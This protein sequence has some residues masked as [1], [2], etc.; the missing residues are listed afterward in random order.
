MRQYKVTLNWQGEVHVFRANASNKFGA[1]A[2]AIAGLAKKL[3]RSR[4][5]V[6]QYFTKGDKVKVEVE[7]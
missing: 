3:Q 6:R 4:W 7:E 5:S 1:E 2:F